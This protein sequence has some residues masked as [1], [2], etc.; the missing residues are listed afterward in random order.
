MNNTQD[1]TPV[2][3]M[4]TDDLTKELLATAY[5][6][7]VTDINK[8]P[9]ELA[10][11]RREAFD[12]IATIPPEHRLTSLTR[13]RAV[14]TELGNHTSAPD[15]HDAVTGQTPLITLI[16]GLKDWPRIVL[17]DGRT[18]RVCAAPIIKR[19][20]TGTRTVAGFAWLAYGFGV[21]RT[22]DNPNAFT[23]QVAPAATEDEVIA[24]IEEALAA[25]TWYMARLTNP[26]RT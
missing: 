2:A 16:H 14:L 22:D 4:T 6:H 21:S 5:G 18:G 8:S 17:T 9:D 15:T 3:D 26:N 19:A 13:L 1:R 7:P 24:A 12:R 25:N 11:A 23:D 20:D 10:R